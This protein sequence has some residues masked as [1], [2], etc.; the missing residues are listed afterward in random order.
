[1]TISSA[2]SA[3][4]FSS[5]YNLFEA[6]VSLS[7]LRVWLAIWLYTQ[8]LFCSKFEFPNRVEKG[9]VEGVGY[10]I[11]VILGIQAGGETGSEII[12]RTIG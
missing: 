3:I 2:C 9:L 8:E 11:N 5:F 4:C 10:S 6:L 1:M 7:L 12:P